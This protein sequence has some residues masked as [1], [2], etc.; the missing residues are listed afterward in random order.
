M[1]QNIYMRLRKCIWQIFTLA[2]C[3]CKWFT[4]DLHVVYTTI[5]T[6]THNTGINQFS[7]LSFTD[8]VFSPL[9]EWCVDLDGL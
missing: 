7:S 9:K 8:K 1:P 2:L 5:D 6:Y 4:L 3:K